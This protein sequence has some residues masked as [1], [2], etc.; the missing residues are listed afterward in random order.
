[1]DLRPYIRTIPDYPKEGILFRDIS[2]LLASREALREVIEMLALEWD[3]VDA[4]AMLDARGF[5][6]GSALAFH[7]GV[8]CAMIRKRGKLPGETTATA[9]SLEYGSNE[10]E[11]Q[12]DAFPPG[13]RV[14]V[15]DDL[16]GTGGTAA[17]AGELISRIG[18]YVA[19]YAFVIEL[20]DLHGRE[21]LG[22]VFVSSLVKY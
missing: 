22:D 8:P 19:G 1:M 21:K 10:V 15:V 16:L 9:Y 4:I 12:V 14:L 17:A 18:S 20:E 5:I 11:M 13:T 7:L 3:G 6:F 2:P